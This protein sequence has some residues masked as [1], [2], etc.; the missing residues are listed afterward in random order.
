LDSLELRAGR[1]LPESGYEAL[2]QTLTGQGY[3]LNCDGVFDAETD[4]APFRASPGDPFAGSTP[5]T[6]NR[7][8]PGTGREGGVGFRDEAL[9][10]IV[11]GTDAPLRDPDSGYPSPGGCPHDAT[12][13]LVVD[14][15]QRMDTRLV[16]VAMRPNE[17]TLLQQMVRLAY[18]TDSVFT[19]GDSTAPL[20]LD[21]YGGDVVEQMIQKISQLIGGAH[22]DR[23]EAAVTHDPMGLVQGLTPRELNPWDPLSFRIELDAIGHYTDHWQ[24]ARIMIGLF[25]DGELLSEYQVMVAIPPRSPR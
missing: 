12:H 7:D 13:A 8:L 24:T 2:Y 15:A 14:A 18:D 16:G 3:D 23:L 4:V 25:G 21:W 1:D 22:F 19:D 9:K 10:I 6:E 17:P 5:G 11:Y 20:V